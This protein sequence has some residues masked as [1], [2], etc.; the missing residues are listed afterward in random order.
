MGGVVA[1][2]ASLA[3]LGFAVWP[4]IRHQREVAS[5]SPEIGELVAQR[6]VAIGAIRELDFDRDL[7]NLSDEDHAELRERSKREAVAILKQ[8]RAEEGRIDEEI[9]RAVAALRGES[10]SAG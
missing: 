6:D 7:G 5:A 2:L 4:L 1:L 10:A 8:L 3:A 9:E